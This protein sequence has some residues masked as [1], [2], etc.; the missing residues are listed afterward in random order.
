MQSLGATCMTAPVGIRANKSGECNPVTNRTLHQIVL[1]RQ[2]QE[3]WSGRGVWHVCGRKHMVNGLGNDRE[4]DH[5][6][7]LVVDG[8]ILN[9][10]SRN[11][12]GIHLA[13]DS[14]KYA[15]VLNKPMRFFRAF[16]SV[17]R[18]I[19]GYNSQRRGTARTVPKLIVLFCVLFV[20]KCVLYNCNRVWTQLQLTNISISINLRVP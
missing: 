20:C 5:S 16:S 8:K 10:S 14:E 15:A 18:Q 2:S 9:C 11:R 7:E 17:V 3:R 4:R 12:M 19:P 1:W 13:Q 6:Q